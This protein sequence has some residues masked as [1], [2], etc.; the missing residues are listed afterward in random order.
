MQRAEGDRFSDGRLY[1]LRNEGGGGKLIAAVEYTVADRADLVHALYDAAVFGCESVE[2]ELY[3]RNVVR[4]G[5]FVYNGLAAYRGM[6]E[7][8]AVYAY[9]LA[10]ALRDDGFVIHIEKLIFQRRAAGI[11]NKDLH[12]PVSFLPFLYAPLAKSGLLDYNNYN[13]SILILFRS[14]GNLF[15]CFL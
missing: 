3:R 12:L 1:G 10:G 4:H 11:D 8:G 7:L 2:N 15:L 9:A 6:L 13:K 14:L 5:L